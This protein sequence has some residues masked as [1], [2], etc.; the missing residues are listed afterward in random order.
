MVG[1]SGF[2]PPTSWSRTIP[3]VRL[4]MGGWVGSISCPPTE[5]PTGPFPYRRTVLDRSIYAQPCRV[6]AA[7]HCGPWLIVRTTREAP[8]TTRDVIGAVIIWYQVH[9]CVTPRQ[10]M[11]SRPIAVCASNRCGGYWRQ[12]T[13]LLSL[14]C[15]K[16]I[17]SK[18]I[19]GC[20]RLSCMSGWIVI[21]KTCGLRE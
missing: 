3:K 14:A 4:W 18:A 20:R 13:V 1:A 21:S 11:R 8:C 16:H 2:E 10:T 6:A 9:V 15:F 12:R 5:T 7:K 19:G 17:S